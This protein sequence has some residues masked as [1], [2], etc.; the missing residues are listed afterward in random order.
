MSSRVTGAGPQAALL[1]SAAVERHRAGRLAEA[2]SLYGKLL[3][4]APAEPEAWYALG[5]A[6][7][8]SGDSLSASRSWLKAVKLRPDYGPAW[9]NLGNA[10]AALAQPEAA[11]ASFCKGIALLPDLPEAHGNLAIVL[12]QLDRAAE[13]EQSARRALE[14]RPDDPGLLNNLGML[15]HQLG[16]LEEAEAA[17]RRSLALQPDNARAAFNLS[18]VLLRKGDWAEGWALR[19]ARLRGGVGNLQPRSF[20]QPE[21]AGEDIA[22]K[23]ILLYAEQGFGD[24]LQFLRFCAQI[25]AKVIVEVPRPL[26][27]LAATAA[28]VAQV[29]ASGDNLP[30]FDV[31]LPLM[32]VARI[33]KLEVNNVPA[34]VPYLSAPASDWG[35]KLAAWPGKKVGLVWSG[36]P[37]PHDPLATAVD[38]RRSL[39]LPI[40][41]PLLEVSGVTFVSLQKGAAAGQVR[42][43]DKALRPREVMEGIKDFADTAAL[44]DALDL[45]ITVDTAVAHLAGALGKPVWILS[46][47]DGCWRWLADRDDS[48]WYPTARLFRQ[49]GPGDWQAVVERVRTALLGFV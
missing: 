2:I 34:S 10:Q 25:A 40:L 23:T 6:Q 17:Y 46:R 13:G 38:R 11:E 28:G 32:S 26:V 29:V 20:T 35:K 49:E 4:L 7:M 12:G 45:V 41:K 37:R 19:E 27:R 3:K 5:L 1:M 15:L 36:D 42:K 43:L 14:L 48:P 24:S 16:R 44:V 8:Q 47:F 33:L 18:L 31:H 21:W 22:G 30:E 39:A 9:V